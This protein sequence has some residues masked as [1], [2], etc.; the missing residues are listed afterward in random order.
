MTTNASDKLKIHVTTLGCSKNQYDSEILMGQ[1]KANKARLTE[2]PNQAD[3]VIVNTCGFIAPAKQESIEAI[4]EAGKLKEENPNLKLLVCGCLSKR[5]Y[6][7]LE[8]EIPEVD[9]YFGTEDY[10]QILDYLQLKPVSPEHLYENRYLSRESHFAYL[11]ISEGCNHKC[12]FCAIPLMRGKHRSR[13]I[14]ELVDEARILAES[15]VKEL[16]LIAQDTTFY[17]LD[18]YKRQRIVDLLTEL[19]KVEGLR[20]IRLHYAYPTTFQS[21]LVDYLAESQKVLPYIDIPLQHITDNMLKVMKRGGKSHR[22]RALLAELRERIPGLALRTTFIVG[23]PGETDEDFA[24][25]KEFVQQTRFDRMGV[26]T[27]SP[28]EDTAAYELPAPPPEVAE[29]RYRELMEIQQ[30]ISLELNS[31][32]VGKVFETIIDEYQ[33]ESKT[34]FGRTYADSPEIDNEVII[35]NVS[36]PVKPGDFLRVKITDAGEY[37]LFGQVLEE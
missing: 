7:A 25:L 2:D 13:R 8:E 9:A 4:L 34:A 1:L 17:G 26:F 32:K 35:E 30:Q 37:E 10:A 21:E 27:Y 28:E 33:A 11:K 23:H 22:I 16:I 5:Y 6:T 36:S 3:V 18:L 19:E 12:A 24:V 29:E 20:W 14:S 15:G 31:A